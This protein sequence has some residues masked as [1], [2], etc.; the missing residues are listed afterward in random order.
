MWIQDFLK[1]RAHKWR[2][3]LF[4]YITYIHVS[5]AIRSSQLF[6][7]KASAKKMSH[8]KG[9]APLSPLGSAPVLFKL[10]MIQILTIIKTMIITTTT[11]TTTLII[12]GECTIHFP[13]KNEDEE[14]ARKNAET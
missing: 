12:G 13:A 14:D 9:I 10:I 5:E 3:K 6:R 4:A 8:D 11:T 7:S 2:S 1:G